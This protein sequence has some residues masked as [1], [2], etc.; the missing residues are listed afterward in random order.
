M[1]L[2]LCAAFGPAGQLRIAKVLG[3]DDDKTPL[4]MGLFF[5]HGNA[6]TYQVGWVGTDGRQVAANHYLLWAALAEL[7]AANI[8]DLDLGGI[9][10]DDATAGITAFKG[11]FGGKRVKLIGAYH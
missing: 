4:A 3:P 2:S 8:T 1:I 6:A 11:A 5:L 7:Q 9:N 10:D